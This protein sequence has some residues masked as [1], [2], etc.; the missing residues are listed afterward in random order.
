MEIRTRMRL[1]E[2]EAMVTQVRRG[3]GESRK[4]TGISEVINVP[5]IHCRENS[6]GLP[7]LFIIYLN[8]LC[9]CLLLWREPEVFILLCELRFGFKPADKHAPLHTLT[10]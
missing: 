10:T 1:K 4:T 7:E 3:S 6:P 5:R 9:L 8:V 2:R